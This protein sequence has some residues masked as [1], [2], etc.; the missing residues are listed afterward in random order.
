[1]LYA[2]RVVYF[3]WFNLDTLGASCA[4]T[5]R[6]HPTVR[7]LFLASQW[8]LKEWASILEILRPGA[9]LALFTSA[10]SHRCLAKLECLCTQPHSPN[11]IF[12]QH[13]GWKPTVFRKDSRMY[14]GNKREN[15]TETANPPFDLSCKIPSAIICNSADSYKHYLLVQSISS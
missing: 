13:V 7:E 14:K 9:Y 12:K 3:G 15:C 10:A 1:M 11:V 2:F 4:N 5:H 6:K 8:L